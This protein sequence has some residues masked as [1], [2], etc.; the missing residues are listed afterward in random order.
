MRRE[1]TPLSTDSPIRGIAFML[2]GVLNLSLLDALAK[3]IVAG[4]PIMQIIAIRSAF[5]LLLMVPLI[6]R[7]GGLQAIK[8]RRPYGHAFRALAQVCS[9][10]TFLEALRHLPLAT[11]IAIGFA[12]PLM[13][14]VLSVLFL[15]EKVGIHRWGAVVIGFLGVLVITR[16]AAGDTLT[17]ASLLVL[18]SS[19]FYSLSMVSLRAMAPTE[20]NEALMFYQ[21]GGTLVVG[22]LALP[23]VW[24]PMTVLD[25]GVTVGMAIMLMMGQ[26]LII[27]SYRYASIG[28]VAPFHY[29]ELL[30]TTVLG[31]AI[32]G[33]WPG[34]NVWIGAAIVVASGL[35]ILWREHLQQ[36][37]RLRAPSD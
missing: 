25:T 29:T 14:T 10:V 12:A 19:L 2:A 1:Q 22:L 35:Y 8:T 16:P 24:A 23:F 36:S 30:W 28:A 9:I 11:A 20:T 21:N 15:H 4:N 31:L 3:Y 34:V 37:T 18:A 7:A 32:W 6:L 26:F 5:V 17:A 33:E 13:M 27:Q